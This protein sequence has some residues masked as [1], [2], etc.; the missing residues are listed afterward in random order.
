MNQDDISPAKLDEFNRL[1][2]SLKDKKPQVQDLLE[3]SRAAR[4]AGLPKEARH[5]LLTA[6]ELEPENPLVTEA[7]AVELGPDE[8]GQWRETHKKEIPFWRDMKSILLYPAQREGLMMLGL[9]SL[10]F[11]SGKIF[12]SLLEAMPLLRIFSIVFFALGGILGLVIILMLPGLYTSITRR[13]AAGKSGFPDWPGFGDVFANLLGPALKALAVG[14]WSFM[15]LIM[16]IMA[17]AQKKISPSVSLTVFTLLLGMLYFP[18]SYLM[19]VMSQKLWPSL[20]PS[21]VLDSMA[22]SGRNYLKLCLLFWALLLPSMPALLLWEIPFI[23]P[24]VAVFTGLYCWAC[25]LHLL[26]KFYRYEK[27]KLK[28]F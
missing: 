21:Q 11:A 14:L 13:A 25:S 6:G 12:E 27:E 16:T 17:T 26:G 15:P 20:L 8:F 24:A 4:E 19:M 2:D 18:M 5:N 28:W 3:L 22:K 10:F 23:G 7:L 9:A 1:Q